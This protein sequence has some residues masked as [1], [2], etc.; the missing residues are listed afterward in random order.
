MAVYCCVAVCSKHARVEQHKILSK[1][2]SA[3][4]YALTTMLLLTVTI[5]TATSRAQPN[6]GHL[7][8][9]AAR[10]RTHTL[11]AVLHRSAAAV[12][13][14]AAWRGLQG[15]RVTTTVRAFKAAAT[16]LQ[17]VY[18]GH[19][20]RRAAARVRL[21]RGAKP[22]APRLQ[23]G[24]RLIRD[25]KEAVDRQRIELE[26][27]HASQNRAEKRTSAIHSML[28]ESEKELAV[29]EREMQE[30][31]S[32]QCSSTAA[33]TSAAVGHCSRCSFS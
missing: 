28:K 13:V 10:R 27:L 16:V 24:L 33:H 9:L 26:A 11:R 31:L 20:A 8:R 15:R 29:L 32:D 18:R 14:Q 30:L 2:H 4:K 17:R 22:G 12:A 1:M 19:L 21:W 5:T 3:M 25:T 6:R 7:G 23:L